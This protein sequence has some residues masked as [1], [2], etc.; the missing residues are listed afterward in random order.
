MSKMAFF[1]AACVL[2]VGAIA[3]CSSDATPADD[4]SSGGPG[5]D[6]GVF[7]GD[8]GV[9]DS[10][11]S[12]ESGLG[13]PLFRPDRVFTGF[14]GTNTFKVPVAVYDSDSDLSVTSSDPSG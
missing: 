2:G 1:G 9:A 8:G 12:P 6:S 3:A 14:D 7:K 11:P 13:E 4:G 5:K 10:N